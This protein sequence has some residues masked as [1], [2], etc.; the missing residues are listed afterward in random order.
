MKAFYQQETAQNTS[1]DFWISICLIQQY[2][3][4]TVE[5]LLR[6]PGCPK[7]IQNIK[8]A[9]LSVVCSSGKRKYK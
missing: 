6:F 7:S 8:S 5:W 2:K 9:M 1:V 4:P 3:E